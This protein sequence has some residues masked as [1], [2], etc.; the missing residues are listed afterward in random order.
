VDRVD[1]GDVAMIG[2][3]VLLMVRS[4]SFGQA[5]PTNYTSVVGAEP[6]VTSLRIE[7]RPR[8]DI[9]ARQ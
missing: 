5:F 7:A 4:L 2:A 9:S 1:L 8:T 3:L 6:G